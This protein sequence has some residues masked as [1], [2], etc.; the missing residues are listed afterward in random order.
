MG[1]LG[2]NI[3][4]TASEITHLLLGAGVGRGV[5]WA[6]GEKEERPLLT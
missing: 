5:W 3:L 4:P 2:V 1:S 6:G